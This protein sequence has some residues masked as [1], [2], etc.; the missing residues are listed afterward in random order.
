M[1]RHAHGTASQALL[2]ASR[3]SARPLPG[4]AAMAYRLHAS[5]R[6]G[7]EVVA[8]LAG[9]PGV[10]E[11]A[12]LAVMTALQAADPAVPTTLTLVSRAAFDALSHPAWTP[13]R[14]TPIAAVEARAAMLEAASA[15]SDLRVSLVAVTDDDEMAEL[16][17]L[18]QAE[19]DAW[20]A[21]RMA[22]LPPPAMA[23]SQTLLAA[24]ASAA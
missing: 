20:A 9:S 5:D 3:V 2:V 10:A 4:A 21:E 6:D 15:F 22:A 8:P 12:M 7:E 1:P 14:S 18:A 23:A 16:A 17:G 19:A 11:A 24:P 13:S